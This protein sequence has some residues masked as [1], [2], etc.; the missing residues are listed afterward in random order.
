MLDF[1]TRPTIPFELECESQGYKKNLAAEIS[2]TAVAINGMSFARL[3]SSTI[4]IGIAFVVTCLSH[5]LFY[6]TVCLDK[7]IKDESVH[8]K[9][10]TV[11]LTV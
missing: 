2:S 1:Y 8:D 5:F 7:C 11:Y 6:V 10:G 3:N 9:I 4:G